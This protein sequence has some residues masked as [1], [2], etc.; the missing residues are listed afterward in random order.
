MD[1]EKFISSCKTFLVLR[2]HGRLETLFSS[3]FLSLFLVPLLATMHET[4]VAVVRCAL[5]RY[6]E[7]HPGTRLGPPRCT[8]ATRPQGRTR[9]RVMEVCVSGTKTGQT[10]CPS[11]L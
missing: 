3:F 6:F 7:T 1:H 5:D 2:P 10:H 11:P 4:T 9:G 8:T